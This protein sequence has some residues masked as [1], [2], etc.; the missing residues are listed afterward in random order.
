M[1]RKVPTEIIEADKNLAALQL[2]HDE[3]SVPLTPSTYN[4]K[5]NGEPIVV[6]FQIFDH[7]FIVAI[8][9]WNKDVL[10]E[11]I[12]TDGNIQ[13]VWRRFSDLS[14]KHQ[15]RVLDAIEKFSP[16]NSAVANAL[17]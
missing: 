17:I 14:T 9:P 5:D 11:K 7:T 4:L 10:Y 2:E 12:D 15:I 1:R 6:N 16:I 8:K 13:Q 3:I